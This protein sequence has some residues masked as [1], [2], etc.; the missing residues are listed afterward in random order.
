[1]GV[2]LVREMEY[3]LAGILDDEDIDTD[4]EE[5]GGLVR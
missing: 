3:A 1:M 5:G 2:V 4:V